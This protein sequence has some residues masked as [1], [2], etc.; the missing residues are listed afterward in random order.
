MQAKPIFLKDMKAKKDI[1]AG[2]RKNI[3]FKN[4]PQKLEM[5]IGARSYYRVFINGEFVLFGPARAPHKH[6]RIDR[7][8]ILP[9][10]KCGEN[11]LA[12]E[13]MGYNI[14][15]NGF[16]TYEESLVVAEVESD[17]VMI[18]KTDDSWHAG[19]LSQKFSNV[20]GLAFGR[21]V[22]AENYILDEEYSTWKVEKF[23][24]PV[25]CEYTND[26]VTY[27][28]RG[29]LQADFSI[30]RNFKLMGISSRIYKATDYPES[31]WWQNSEYVESHGSSE[32]ERPSYEYLSE[33][34][35]AYDGNIQRIVS[36]DG[37]QSYILTD[38]K[39]AATMEFDFTTPAT[40]FVGISFET[41]EPAVID[42]IYNDIIDDNG[43]VPVR[44]DSINRVIR[45]KSTGGKHDFLSFD[46]EFAKFIKIVV[47]GG[48]S[49]NLKDIYFRKGQY[50]QVNGGHFICSDAKLNR[51]YEAARLTLITCTF[52]YFMDCPG[53][54]RG[55]WSGDSYWTGR[56]ARILL[57][58]NLVEKTMLENFLLS[59]PA[60]C[61]DGSFIACCCGGAAKENNILFNWNLFILY[62][63]SDYFKRT[64]D[65][66]LVGRFAER[67]STLLNA[68][69]KYEN[70][71]GLLQ[72]PPGNIFIDW[73][74]SNDGN[75]TSPISTA[76]NAFYA[77]VLEEMF[78]LYG[79]LEYKQ[80][81]EK[82]RDILLNFYNKEVAA[83]KF[84]IFTKYPFMPDS[85]ELV[86]GQLRG[87]GVYTEGAQYYYLWTKLLT[88]E[89]AADLIKYL[90]KAFGPDPENYKGTSHLS[91]APCGI[92]FG[93]MIRMEMLSIIGDFTRLK[94]EMDKFCGYMIDNGPGTFWET[95][96]GEDSL[97][98]SFGS[99]FGVVI[100]RDFLG[101]EMPDEIGKIINIA[102]HPVDL[103]WAKGSVSVENGI[104]SVS[105][106]N[107]NDCFILYASAPSDY[108]LNVKFPD[109]FMYR[110]KL[111]VNGINTLVTQNVRAK[112]NVTIIY[113]LT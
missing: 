37:K 45:L 36:S 52:D 80:R 90:S 2:F 93:H 103:R 78:N 13:V 109:E 43:S 70:E 16:L 75:S 26:E 57:G 1:L 6:L 89:N 55:G 14:R 58:D 84:D 60:T 48:K 30:I 91:V 64:N 32:I 87:K 81:S 100:A 11:S 3:I 50:P 86:D 105:W 20:E 97:N 33:T 5:R 96:S 67:V 61:L 62:E 110:K 23:K 98:H 8:D 7:I 79:I 46:F 39:L 12:I 18:A 24:F 71:V 111:V 10:V 27:L 65:G 108:T 88:K 76:T 102:P 69:Q 95:T 44:S 9:Y 34:D 53:R 38:Y 21:R 106:Q 41:E 83:R 92:F 29:V 112:G 66:E 63:L 59:T 73:S 72:S 77:L 15:D 49:F 42:I 19:I 113:E 99:H 54:E 68:T 25:P 35:I 40:G 4:I 94:K 107:K 22:P 104:A 74:A 17:G 82:T 51:I 31:T 47:R 56:A 28:E 101:L 85:M